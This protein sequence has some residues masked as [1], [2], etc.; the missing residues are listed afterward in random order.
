MNYYSNESNFSFP[1][2][3]I[4]VHHPELSDIERSIRMK[5]LLDA[6]EDLLKDLA[7]KKKEKEENTCIQ[8]FKL[9]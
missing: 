1:G 6:S 7:A 5:I 4:K 3:V 8:A 2:V 9:H